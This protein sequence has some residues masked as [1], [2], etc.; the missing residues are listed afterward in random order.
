MSLTLLKL[1]LIM[2]NDILFY[3]RG[4]V[5]IDKIPGWMVGL[6]EEDVVFIK[7]FLLSSGFLKKLAA[8]YGVTY[9]TVRLRFDRLIDK[10]EITDDHIDA[11]YKAMVKRM[12]IDNKIS[13]EAAKQLI[14]E[15]R[16]ENKI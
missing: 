16:K 14:Q 7:N 4:V 10:I 15:Y 1:T 9:P 3:R 13:F 5:M 12:V 11:P 6:E 2:L 8:H